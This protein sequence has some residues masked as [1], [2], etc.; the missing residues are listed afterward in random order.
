MKKGPNGLTP[1]IKSWRG[2]NTTLL[3]WSLQPRAALLEGRARDTV[4]EFLPLLS[5]SRVF[6]PKAE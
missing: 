3:W 4:Y 2:S 5:G 1:S 6:L